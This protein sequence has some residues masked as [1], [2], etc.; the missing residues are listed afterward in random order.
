MPL[1][2]LTSRLRRLVLTSHV[3]FSVGWLGAVAAYLALAITGLTSSD[4]EMM[5]AAYLSMATIAWIVIV[6]CSIAALA[7][8]LVQS[9]TTE[10]GLFR[11]YWV[12][13]KFLLT[14]AAVTVLLLHMP[15]VRRMAG[16]AAAWGGSAADVGALQI[17]LVIHAGGGLLVLLTA[18]VLSVYKPWGRIRRSPE[19][20]QVS[21]RDS[22]R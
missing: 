22:R 11:H 2:T 14:V 1:I 12:L 4:A 13:A 17:Q 6:P 16:I 7:S 19:A 5:R 10:W 18:T 8:G 15:T 9:L 20:Y 3:T 21:S